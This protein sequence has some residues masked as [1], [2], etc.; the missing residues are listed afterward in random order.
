MR[1]NILK[2]ALLLLSCASPERVEVSIAPVPQ[3]GLGR[4]AYG[5]WSLTATTIHEAEAESATLELSASIA[6][7]HG[8]AVPSS[9]IGMFRVSRRA[10]DDAGGAASLVTRSE[11]Q[12]AAGGA[13]DVVAFIRRDS[14]GDLFIRAQDLFTRTKT[15]G[16]VNGWM[17]AGGFE[18]SEGDLVSAMRPGCIDR[19]PVGPDSEQSPDAGVGRLDEDEARAAMPDG[20]T[21]EK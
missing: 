4:T 12:V 6:A 9:A 21:A 16:F 11:G 20:G 17:Y 14:R 8:G 15:G 2:V 10:V 7:V 18:L 5:L 19:Y 3:C 1:V 13:A